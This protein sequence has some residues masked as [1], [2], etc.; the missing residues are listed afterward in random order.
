MLKHVEDV[1]DRSSTPEGCNAIYVRDVG[2]RNNL[3]DVNGFSAIP[4]NPMYIED[5]YNL[6]HLQHK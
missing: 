1:E 5:Y 6:R 2:D 4:S 3:F